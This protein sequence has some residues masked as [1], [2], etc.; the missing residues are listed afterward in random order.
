MRVRANTNSQATAREAPPTA[1][2]LSLGMTQQSGEDASGPNITL[3]DDEIREVDRGT[4][5]S[6]SI[7]DSANVLGASVEIKPDQ[8]SFKAYGVEINRDGLFI[9]GKNV[10]EIHQDDLRLLGELGRGACSVVKQ[11]QVRRSEVAGGWEDGGTRIFTTAVARL[12][13][14]PPA[15][16]ILIV[17]EV[18]VYLFPN[19][20]CRK[21]PTLVFC[22][23]AP[24]RTKHSPTPRQL[25]ARASCSSREEPSKGQLA[26][27]TASAPLLQP[28]PSSF[29]GASYRAME[30]LLCFS[31]AC[32]SIHHVFL[33]LLARTAGVSTYRMP[34]VSVAV[35]LLRLRLLLLPLSSEE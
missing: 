31:A 20:L 8:V 29:G 24:T 12:E 11:A 17:L 16:I 19:V 13:V 6:L 1:S 4:L 30:L 2:A 32:C 5:V 33:R 27:L 3:D 25:L 18:L 34:L 7:P 9:E 26:W 15:I 35:R 22:F 14:L 28:C 10:S 23:L 21:G